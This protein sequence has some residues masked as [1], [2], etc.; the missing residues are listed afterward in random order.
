MDQIDVYSLTF[1]GEWQL[2]CLFTSDGVAYEP[3]VFVLS[4]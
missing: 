3:W 2:V 1:R 4:C